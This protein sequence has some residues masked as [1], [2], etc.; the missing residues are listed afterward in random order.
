MNQFLLG[1]KQK[2]C[3]IVNWRIQKIAGFCE[4][5]SF[6]LIFQGPTNIQSL[7]DSILNESPLSLKL[8]EK[9]STSEKIC[10]VIWF[11]LI[12]IS[13][14]LMNWFDVRKPGKM[15]YF[16]INYILVNVLMSVLAYLFGWWGSVTGNVLGKGPFLYYVRVF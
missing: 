14:L 12:A 16:I 1:L 4:L 7:T 13:W 5:Y 15:N 10:F 9:N 8:S 6:Y 2:K 3:Y 11:P